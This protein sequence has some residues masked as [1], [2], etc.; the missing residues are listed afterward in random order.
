VLWAS[1]WN[2][3][4]MVETESHSFEL[5]DAPARAIAGFPGFLDAMP[6]YWWTLP[7]AAVALGCVRALLDPLMKR[8]PALGPGFRLEL[9]LLTARYEAA[10]GY[11]M[12]TA[13]RAGAFGDPAYLA[14]VART[15]THVTREAEALAAALFALGG[16]T[17]FRDNGLPAKFLRDVFA[18]TGLRPPVEYALDTLGDGLQHWQPP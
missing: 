9:A 1:D 5:R 16:G 12:D 13:R 17:A 3:F 7:F 14:L 10:R 6:G 11:L 15:K 2:G 4:G 18:G 8:A